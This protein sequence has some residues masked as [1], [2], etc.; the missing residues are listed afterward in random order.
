ML[1]TCDSKAPLIADVCKRGGAWPA[2][3]DTARHLGSRHTLGLQYLTRL[4]AHHGR[5]SAPCP[6][7]NTDLSDG[8]TTLIDRVLQKHE[9]VTN[10]SGFSTESVI[11]MLTNR[12]I[13]FVYRFRSLF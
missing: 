5:G 7:C 10:L 9:G 4:L 6:Q 12:D 11:S 8:A 1:A 2:L 3:W 13:T